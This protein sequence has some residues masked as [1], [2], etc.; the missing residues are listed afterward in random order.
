MPY[1]GGAKSLGELFRWLQLTFWDLAVGQ[2]PGALSTKWQREKFPEC[3]LA[4]FAVC[5]HAAHSKLCAAECNR[6]A[7]GRKKSRR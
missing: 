3:K 2:S 1:N 6:S 4:L 5:S 7:R